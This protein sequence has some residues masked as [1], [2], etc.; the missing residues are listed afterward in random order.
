MQT[1]EKRVVQT[2]NG[3]KPGYIF[4]GNYKIFDGSYSEGEKTSLVAARN[5]QVEAKIAAYKAREE[6]DK[7]RNW[8]VW[9]TPLHLYCSNANQEVPFPRPNFEKHLA[10]LVEASARKDQNCVL[11]AL[12]IGITTGSQWVRFLSK[13]RLNLAGTNLTDSESVAPELKE[14]VVACNSAELHRFFPQGFFDLVVSHFGVKMQLPE[15]IENAIFVSK[16]GADII[17]S[18]VALSPLSGQ[19]GRYETVQMC[20]AE[21]P[22]YEVV[23]SEVPTIM[24]MDWFLWLRKK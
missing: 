2:A 4:K 22:H 1:K 13:Y 14:K 17:L 12:D 7:F 15:L 10:S 16:R 6:K 11:N 8:D 19:L 21:N 23:A 9:D 20:A 3:F 5:R 24:Y 18:D